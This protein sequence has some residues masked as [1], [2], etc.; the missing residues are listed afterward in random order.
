[1]THDQHNYP[2]RE[3]I[4]VGSN[5]KPQEQCS[6]ALLFQNTIS[7]LRTTVAFFAETRLWALSK[8]KPKM[9]SWFDQNHY[10]RCV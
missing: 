7:K 5:V 1:M 4:S 10:E 8:L 2:D 9:H 6:R 3:S